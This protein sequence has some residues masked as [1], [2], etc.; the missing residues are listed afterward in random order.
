MRLL[1]CLLVHRA[2][3]ARWFVACFVWSAG[4]LTDDR[5]DPILPPGSNPGPGSGSGSGSGS[6]PGPGGGAGALAG[7]PSLNRLVLSSRSEEIVQVDP[8]AAGH[9]VIF[10]FDRLVDVTSLAV[11]GNQIFAG[12]E[13]NSINAIDATTHQFQWDAPL[14]RYE[15]SSLADP[16][17]VLR[18]GVVYATGIPGVL[19]AH[20]IATGAKQWQ[21]AMDPSGD[22]D[23]YYSSV[24]RTALTADRVF[25]GTHSSLDQNYLHAIDR[26]TGARVWRIELEHGV[27]G[28]IKLVGN[29]LI[30]PAGDLYA[31]DP[32]T[33]AQ[34][35]RFA[36]EPLSRGAGTPAIA[37]TAVL[38][39]GAADVA[40]GRLY[41]LDLATGAERWSIKAGNDY[42]GIYAPLVVG[43]VVLGVAERGSGVSLTGNGLPFVADIATG[44]VIWQNADVSVETSPVFANGR[45]FFHGQNFRGSGDIDDNVGLLI[46]DAPTGK[47]LAID[48]YFRYSVALTPIVIA[49]NG[50]FTGSFDEPQ[51]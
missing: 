44:S 20:A 40:D 35:W 46:L 11:V 49:T 15:T 25:V 16:W 23:S 17:V 18:D 34:R 27:S 51:P 28:V 26:A 48:N 10:S 31:L 43:G 8:D 14:G 36:M 6:D 39:Q 41:C 32:A 37:G 5:A 38:V 22:T 33:G 12:A 2:M 4:C 47:F 30:V 7:D 29:T 19:Q 3:I 1:R 45:L 24:G 9:Q 21:Y 13:D 42:A 50:T